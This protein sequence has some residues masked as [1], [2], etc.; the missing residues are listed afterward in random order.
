MAIFDD[1]YTA[2][3][4]GQPFFGQ[5]LTKLNLEKRPA[6]DQVI[7]TL[8]VSHDT[9]FYNEAFFASLS[10]DEGIAAITHEVLHAVMAHMVD[11]DMYRQSMIG[12]DGK[13]FNQEKYNEACDYVVNDVIKQN[14]IG[15]L[16]PNWY[17]D[18]AYPHTMTPAEIYAALP[19]RP[20]NNNQPNKAGQSGQDTHISQGA[21][22]AAGNT[23]ITPADVQAA[24]NTA[25]AMGSLPV[26][27]DRIIQEV[28]KPRHSPW[29][30]LRTAM[31]EAFRGNERSTWRRLNR[32]MLPRG[33]IMPG[34]T[35][36]A[37]NRVG[38]V[39][40][41]SGSIGDELIA[42]FGGHMAAI[43]TDAKPKE[44][45]VYW[46]DAEVHR[47]DTIKNGQ[48]LKQ[49]LK[50]SIPGGGGTD[51]PT[52]IKAAIR[53]KCESIAVL[54]DGYTPFGNAP[55]LPV[56]WAITSDVKAPYGKTIKIC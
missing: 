26:G 41:T 25:K 44:I 30:M 28:V 42:L 14:Q 55:K 29:A 32:H 21:S 46:T 33:V 45:K 24:A 16:S 7:K 38:V 23:G 12:P 53:D 15:A 10:D 34:R 11:I 22:Q 18:P 47:V 8:A 54:T 9:L 19:D 51:M 6:T 3:L 43:L 56:V 35:G 27:M 36:F 20:R 2:I 49:I 48:Q 50:G 4:L 5:L 52:G 13:A 37:T 31:L 39:V 17:W 40:D 1:A